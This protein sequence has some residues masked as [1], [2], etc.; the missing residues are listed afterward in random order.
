MDETR[1]GR[2]TWTQDPDTGKWRLSERFETNFVDLAGT[3]GLL[4]P[5]AGRTTTAVTGW[6]DDLG[7]DWKDAVQIVAMDPCATYRR[8][9]QQALPQ[10]L[11]VADHFHLV[12]LANQALTEVRQRVTRDLT[13]RRGL[14]TDPV[15]A[16][17]RRLL[18]GRERLSD[19]AFTTMWNGLIDH[20]DT[21]Q[22]LTAWIA[23][24]ELR[25]LLAT[26]RRGA[27]RSDVA[28]QA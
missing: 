27:V 21:G 19:K 28:H 15:W 5:C 22:V 2:P 16:N 4:G 11:I 25:T 12:R 10:A 8:A 23:K 20:A 7:Q 14:K 13:G 18:R 1:R 17:R 26:A 9:V 6:L 24:E 3:Q